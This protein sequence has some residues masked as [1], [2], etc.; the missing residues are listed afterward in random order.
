[1]HFFYDEMRKEAFL[2]PK[3]ALGLMQSASPLKR[4][5]GHFGAKIQGVAASPATQELVDSI[6]TGAQTVGPAFALATA[7][8]AAAR[9]AL[10]ASGISKR[11]AELATF[12]EMNSPFAKALNPLTPI[13]DKAGNNIMQYGSRLLGG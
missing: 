4:K 12:E 2:T 13:I 9:E 10:K 8:G 7:K 11:V 1:M 5:L 6:N 3:S